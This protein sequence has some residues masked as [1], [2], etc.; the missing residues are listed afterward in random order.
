M[1]V[2]LVGCLFVLDTEKNK[3][4]RKNDIQKIKIL[5]TKDFGLPS[6]LF[7]GKGVK[8]QKEQMAIQNLL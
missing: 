1:K 2:N 3:N 8:N 7:E 5:T 4:I 6:V